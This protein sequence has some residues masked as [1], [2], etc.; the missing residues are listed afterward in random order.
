MEKHLHPD[1]RFLPTRFSYT[2]SS[3]H[4]RVLY[5]MTGITNTVLLW[6]DPNSL[7]FSEKY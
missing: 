7:I 4:Y 2:S 6:Y 1:K 5:G 3:L